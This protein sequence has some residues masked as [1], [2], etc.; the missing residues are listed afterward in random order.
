MIPKI[1]TLFS[2]IIS[3]L[4]AAEIDVRRHIE[5]QG[6]AEILVDPDFATWQIV[7]RGEADSLSEASTSLEESS[8][9][10]SNSL[11]SS[12][13]PEESIKLSA[14]SSGRHYD[15]IKNQRV[16]MG[17][18][19]ERRVLVELRDLNRRQEVE[20]FF[21]KDDRVEIIAITSQSS[22]HEANRQKSLLSAAAIAKEK[23]SKL[24]EALGAKVGVVLSIQQGSTGY[25]VI[26]SNRIEMPVFGAKPSQLEYLSYSSTIT[27]KFELK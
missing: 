10:L 27:V 24:A 3:T 9:A 23:A 2:L 21:L 6:T 1:V 16:F 11:A 17:F 22:E 25:A 4:L 8:N 20:Q 13:F 15:I 7:I 14:I 5:V 26:T 12:G 18:F 19:A